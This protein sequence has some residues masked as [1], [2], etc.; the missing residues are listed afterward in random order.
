M[1][2]D[3]LDRAFGKTPEMFTD[4]IDQTLQGLE[5]KPVKRITL[6]AA[7]IAAVL[8]ALLCGIA[9][10]VITQGQE[11]YYNNRFTAYQKYEPEKYEAIM[12]G[13]QGAPDQ[14]QQ[15]D[16]VV[17]VVVQDI[18]W[19][20]EQKLMTISLAARPK[21]ESEVE[22]HPMWNLDADGSYVGPE[23]L[24]EYADD[25]EARGEHWLWTEKGFGPVNEMME[26]ASKKLYLFEADQ[27][28][29]G[30]SA[31]GVYLMGDGSS[32]DCFVGEDGAVITVL[33]CA[34][35]WMDEAYDEQI[36]AMEGMSQENR[37]MLVEQ[38]RAQREAL[39]MYTDE[40]G[41]LTLTVAYTV[42]EYTNDDM[43]LY[44]GGTQG[45]ITFQVK[46]N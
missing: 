29:I 26:D 8:L 6:R 28:Y 34:M 5:E 35:P 3:E 33:E 46:V 17:N 21:N 15:D 38:N 11:W 36:L 32:M 1:R 19:L 24:D 13:L 18:A 39:E 12:N 37:D 22:L 41:L 9:Y 14:S 16:R 44:T 20:P 30:S 45:T 31:D 10:A 25:E 42:S 23:N 27:I 4:R 2:N 43:A 7:V 40:E